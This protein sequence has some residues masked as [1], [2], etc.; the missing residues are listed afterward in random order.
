[1]VMSSLSQN[2]T[3]PQTIAEVEALAAVRALEFA[4]EL[5]GLNLQSLKAIQ[6]RS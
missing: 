2:I 4:R 1:M 3:L 5:G 6:S